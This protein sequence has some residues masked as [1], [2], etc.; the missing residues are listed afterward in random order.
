MPTA[1]GSNPVMLR[2]CGGLLLKTAEQVQAGK[3]PES[4]FAYLVGSSERLSRGKNRQ[5]EA[6]VFKDLGYLEDTMAF[7][8]ASMTMELLKL[9]GES[10]E[11]K[12]AKENEIFAAEMVQAVKHHICCVMFT[13]AVR[14]FKSHTFKD[15]NCKKLAA[16]IIRVFALKQL[17][18]SNEILYETGYFDKGSKKALHQAW[19]DTMVEI[20]P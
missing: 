20:R 1:E 7:R 9:M 6:G 12:Q 13:M 2:Q 16:A 17:S 19:K 5:G 3:K 11:S 14:Y 8:A 18:D 4:F 10:K 15:E